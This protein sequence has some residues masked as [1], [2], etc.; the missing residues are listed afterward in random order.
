MFYVCFTKKI[1]LMDKNAIIIPKYTLINVLILTS[2]LQESKPET[3]HTIDKILMTPVHLRMHKKSS[4]INAHSI[5]LSMYTKIFLI[6]YIT[7]HETTAT[8]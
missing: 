1:I 2:I 4:T 3:L 6:K 7:Y 5:R 8:S